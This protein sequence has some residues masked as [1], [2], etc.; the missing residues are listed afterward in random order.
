MSVKWPLFD[1]LSRDGSDFIGHE[2]EKLGRP[3]KGGL[4]CFLQRTVSE[5][6]RWRFGFGQT[7][8]GWSGG[9]CTVFW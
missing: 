1:K 8:V 7:M 2:G 5:A 3:S 6:C 9:P 4:L